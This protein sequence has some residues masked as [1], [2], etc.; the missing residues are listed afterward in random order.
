[1][2]DW[3][4]VGYKVLGQACAIKALFLYMDVEYF[5]NKDR[6]HTHPY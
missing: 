1:M 4:L 6:N 5:Y 2:V 3:G